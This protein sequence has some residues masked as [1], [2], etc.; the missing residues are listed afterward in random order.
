M[1]IRARKLD[2][3]DWA[4]PRP[5]TRRFDC[6]PLIQDRIPMIPDRIRPLAYFVLTL[7]AVAIAAAA[8]GNVANHYIPADKLPWYKE[9]PALPVELAPLWGNRTQGEAGTLLRTPAGFDSGLH[10]HTADYWAVV[11][12][13]TWKHWVPATGEGIGLTLEPGAHWT[14][15]HTQLHQD[16]CVS[17]VPCVIFLLNKDPY[18]TE[19]PKPGK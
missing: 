15:V 11:V 18:V 1:T 14:Q 13:G 3:R 2:V 19:F 10:S 8:Q 12:Q 7:G 16:A 6:L 9:S 17:K 4:G 5:E